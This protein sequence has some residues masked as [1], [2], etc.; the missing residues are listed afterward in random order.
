MVGNK[1]RTPGILFGREL[2]AKKYKFIKS[3]RL[4]EFTTELFLPSQ[5]VSCCM[6]EAYTC[7][8]LEMGGFLELRVHTRI[9]MLKINANVVFVVFTHSR[10]TMKMMNRIRGTITN[11]L[12]VSIRSTLKT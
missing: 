6:S 11:V 10:C 3:F 1:I 12:K 4:R 8:Q 2:F 5:R 9:Q 7:C